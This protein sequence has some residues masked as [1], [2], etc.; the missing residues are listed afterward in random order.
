M[1]A[2]P[3]S[4]R[5]KAP[6]GPG[7]RHRPRLRVIYTEQQI[8][9]RV[10]GLAAQINRAHPRKTLDIVGVKDDSFLFMA[11]LVRALVM[12]VVCHFVNVRMYDA[13]VGEAPVREIRYT[14][15]LD[16][17]GKDVLLVQCLLS[18]GVTLDFLHRHIS[19]QGPRSLR[20]VALIEKPQER[21]VDVVTDYLA[22]KSMGTE[23]HFLVGYGLGYRGLYRNL[24]CIA[25][26]PLSEQAS[27]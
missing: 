14:P 1:K 20:T 6:A 13:L 17:A 15:A 5:R 2:A 10:R 12:P 22:F 21:K 4:R 7:A 24:P 27:R 16:L 25:A 18:T 8:R 19:A 11:D 23:R 26:L 3:A 9:R